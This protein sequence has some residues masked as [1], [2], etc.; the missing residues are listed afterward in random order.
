MGTH[1]VI[2]DE[3]SHYQIGGISLNS[4]RKKVR[5]FPDMVA[6]HSFYQTLFA[7]PK[8]YRKMRLA[9]AF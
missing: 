8:K 6:A 1:F 5:E 7:R 3:F 9:K 2:F 4:W